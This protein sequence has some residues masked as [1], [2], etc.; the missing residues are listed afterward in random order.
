[1]ELFEKATK[2]LKG[3]KDFSQGLAIL[4][5]SGFKP[6]VIRKLAR[7]GANGPSCRE[8]LEFQM[9]EYVKAFGI[10]EVPDT[11]PEL[12]VFN[13]EESPVDTPAETSII[14]L[15]HADEKGMSGINN[16]VARKVI[17]LYAAAYRKREQAMHA[18]RST[19]ESNDEET[20]RKR[21][22]LSNN[23]DEYTSLMERLY[24][25]YERYKSGADI[26]EQEVEK[27][28]KPNIPA[29]KTAATKSGAAPTSEGYNLEGKSREE[30]TEMKKN[31]R[32]RY[33]KTK[34]KLLYQKEKKQKVENPMPP[35]AKRTK[36]EVRL[37]KEK[38]LMD[39][40]DMAIAKFG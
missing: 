13:G 20:M 28:V 35:G 17:N 40:I 36:L 27:A 29:E 10:R 14:S 39:A 34:N 37:A 2:W 31:A 9:R 5:E 19:G 3:K 25:L 23:I 21:R 4:Q 38:K 15:A 12:H 26:S 30:L 24:P 33:T 11:D 1:M 16:P 22:V 32:S 6:G 18:M 8:R 7:D